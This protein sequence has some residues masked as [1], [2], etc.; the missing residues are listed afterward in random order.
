[1][2]GMMRICISSKIINGCVSLLV[3]ELNLPTQKEVVLL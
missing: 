1:V 2:Q 3:S